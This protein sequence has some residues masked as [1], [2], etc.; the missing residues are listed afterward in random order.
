[1]RL[2]PL[3]RL[4]CA[5]AACAAVGAGFALV[6]SSALPERPAAAGVLIPSVR[7]EILPLSGG[8]VHS[9]N[10]SGYAVRSKS[11]NIAGVTGTF[12]VPR[13]GSSTLGAAATWAG[14]GGFKTQDLIQAG[15]G[16]D[17]VPS[18]L[19]GK[20]YF[21]WYEML[22][23]PE[24]P[25]HGCKGDTHCK[26]SP[27]NHISVSISNVSGNSWKIAVGN[28]GHWSWSKQVTYNSSRSSADWILE[29]PSCAF[30]LALADVGTV[31]FGPASKYTTGGS[32]HTIR[33]GNPVKI[34]LNGAAK[35]S[36][37]GAD[38]QSF[39]DCAYASGTCR[40]P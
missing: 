11:H 2:A 26:V 35:P 4:V 7:G 23:R 20:K 34:I 18:F 1:V 28:A 32:S 16:E 15:T 25:L 5:V 21:A 8:T 17:S 22:P 37:L 10:W 39:N 13:A 30:C 6:A 24:V 36:E 38:G 19:F 14:I 33:Q 12:V 27:G 40:R 31:H 3:I 29:L 9:Q